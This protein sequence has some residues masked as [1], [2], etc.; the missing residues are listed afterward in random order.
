MSLCEDLFERSLK[1]VLSSKVQIKRNYRPD[2]LKNPKT[3]YN[4]EYDFFISKYNIAFEIQGPHH[5]ENKDQIERDKFK[6]IASNKNN[7]ILMF[8]SIFQIK[9]SIIRS[10]LLSLSYAKKTKIDFNPFDKIIYDQINKEI[11]SYSNTVKK[12]FGLHKCQMP[13]R[14]ITAKK[15]KNLAIS[16]IGKIVRI[17]Y[18]GLIVVCDVLSETSTGKN[19]ILKIGGRFKYFSHGQFINSIVY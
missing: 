11:Y 17:K 12:K 18:K 3:G 2:W 1:I 5:Y 4:L 10:K 13:E 14:F 16:Y 7:V 6:R 8:L 9:P 19:L 15:N